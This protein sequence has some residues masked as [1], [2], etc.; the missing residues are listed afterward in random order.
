MKRETTASRCIINGIEYAR[1]TCSYRDE[2]GIMRK[3]AFYGKT[4]KEV[5]LKKAKF[6]VEHNN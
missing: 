5:A 3:K 6:Q 1:M 2:N 4:R